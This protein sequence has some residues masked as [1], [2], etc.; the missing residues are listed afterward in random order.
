MP[1]VKDKSKKD[2]SKWMDKSLPES[3]RAKLKKEP[4]LEGALNQ[5]LESYKGKYRKRERDPSFREAVPYIVHP[6]RVSAIASF[7][8]KRYD[9]RGEALRKGVIAALFHDVIE[10]ADDKLMMKQLLLNKY[11]EEVALLIHKLSYYPNEAYPHCSLDLLTTAPYTNYTNYVHSILTE[12]DLRLPI[13]KLADIA[14]NLFSNPKETSKRKYILAL[15]HSYLCH[16]KP[17]ITSRWRNA[18]KANTALNFLLY[19][20]PSFFIAGSR[21][22]D[23]DSLKVLVGRWVTILHALK[24][25][26]LAKSKTQF[27]QALYPLYR[28]LSHL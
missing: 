19:R 28:T 9:I 7:L 14:D 10:E 13:I 17:C 27:I 5:A 21:F 16:L 1:R 20:Y 6:L 22:E 24:E 8:L 11:G 12:D 15:E 2:L 3:F 18:R 4:L 26:S 23:V 25:C